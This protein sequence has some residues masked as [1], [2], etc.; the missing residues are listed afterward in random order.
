[1]G[2][3]STKTKLHKLLQTG[4]CHIRERAIEREREGGGV[5]VR[6]LQWY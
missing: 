1:M 6:Y 2:Q 3:G 5:V 4:Y